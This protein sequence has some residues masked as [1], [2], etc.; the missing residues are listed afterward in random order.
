MKDERH[1]VVQEPDGSVAIAFNP[2]VP[3]PPDSA[4]H[5]PKYN[6]YNRVARIHYTLAAQVCF[7]IVLLRHVYTS[8]LS[9]A[10]KGVLDATEYGIHRYN[11]NCSVYGERAIFCSVA[12][13]SRIYR[14][15]VIYNYSCNVFVAFRSVSARMSGR[16]V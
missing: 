10:V 13:S 2:E 16:F 4:Y 6:L 12:Y 7:C 5:H 9:C 8:D 14:G 15:S 3:P 11:N 1:L